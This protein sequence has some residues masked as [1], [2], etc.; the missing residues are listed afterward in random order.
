MKFDVFFTY[1]FMLSAMLFLFTTAK[2]KVISVFSFHVSKCFYCKEKA[3]FAA[4]L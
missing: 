3:N 4:L 2:A 1:L